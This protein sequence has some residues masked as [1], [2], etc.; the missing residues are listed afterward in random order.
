[1]DPCIVVAWL[2]S[3]LWGLASSLW[4]VFSVTFGAVRWAM[5]PFELLLASVLADPVAALPSIVVAAAAGVFSV[6]CAIVLPVACCASV[7]A[8]VRARARSGRGGFVSY[9]L[10]ELRASPAW[11]VMHSR[12]LPWPLRSRARRLLCAAL[13]PDRLS[14]DGAPRGVVRAAERCLQEVNVAWARL[15]AR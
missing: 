7:W 9:S 15:R 12:A 11:R 14:A 6:V 10:E 2:Q 3:F 13:H 5:R 4:W 1:M 8:L